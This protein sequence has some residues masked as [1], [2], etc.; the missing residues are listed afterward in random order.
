M[1]DDLQLLARA[2]RLDQDALAE[3][4]RLYYP[5]LY[6]YISFRV[7]DSMVAEDLTS[8]VFL[9]LLNALRDKHAPQNTIRGWLY[10]VAARVVVDHY[11]KMGKT[12]EIMLDERVTSSDALPEE[13]VA[14]NLSAESLHAVIPNLTDDQQTVLALRF[15]AGMPIKQVADFLQK[16]E[17]AVKQLQLRAVAAL[18]QQLAAQDVNG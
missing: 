9:R 2:R 3:I 6:R 15:G 1:Q 7:S 18:A 12:D 14:Q 10:G 13:I 5:P 11:R 17:G 4:H 16:S 8:E